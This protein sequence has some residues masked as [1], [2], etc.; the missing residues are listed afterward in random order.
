M[1]IQKAVFV[2]SLGGFYLG[3]YP[4]PCLSW[5]S[6]PPYACWGC[7]WLSAQMPNL[8]KRF[9]KYSVF[10]MRIGLFII[11]K[12]KTVF[13]TN[14]STG[15]RRF[16]KSNHHQHETWT[17]LFQT[18]VFFQLHL[19]IFVLSPCSFFDWLLICYYILHRC[20]ER[21]VWNKP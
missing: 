11:F 6:C 3:T 10:Q 18:F 1:V 4:G 2:T 13:K 19:S 12:K 7:M 20:R 17:H 5:V 21:Y 9:R 14:T 8:T 15:L 16:W